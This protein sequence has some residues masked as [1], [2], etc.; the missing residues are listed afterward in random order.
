MEESQAME[1]KKKMEQEL[2]RISDYHALVIAKHTA[3]IILLL[4]FLIYWSKSLTSLPLFYILLANNLLPFLFTIPFLAKKE[5]EVFLLPLF[6]HKYHYSYIH[7]RCNS[8]SF[9]CICIMLF[10]W[11]RQGTYVIWGI[12]FSAL[13]PTMILLL[14]LLLRII[15]MI[16]Y[17]NKFHQALLFLRY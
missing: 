12:S 9:L 5:A 10:L 15:G 1:H 7:Y 13:I 16:Y 4:V 14:L 2:Q 3:N 11:Q 17:R 6:A 8:M